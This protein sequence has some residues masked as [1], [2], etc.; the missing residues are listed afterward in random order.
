[1]DHV[2]KTTRVVP[3]DIINEISVQ[4]LKRISDEKCKRELIQAINLELSI[5]GVQDLFKNL[6]NSKE[7]TKEEIE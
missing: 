5:E 6:I 7:I 4:I 2:K 1:L 3:K